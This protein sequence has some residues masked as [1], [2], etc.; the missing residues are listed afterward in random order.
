MERA[1][2]LIRFSAVL[3]LFF[4]LTYVYLLPGSEVMLEGRTD[5]VMSDDTDPAALPYMYDQLIQ[6]WK[7]APSRFFYGSVYVDNMDPGKGMAYWMSW[8]ERFTMLMAS[9]FFPVEQISTAVVFVMLLLNA[10]SMFALARFLG[11]NIWLS[12]GAAIAWAFNPFTRARATVHMA[13]AG[14]Y[15]LPLIVLALLLVARGKSWR[16]TA[17]AAAALVLACTVNHYFV[18][19]AAF[20]SP[21]FLLFLFFQP[22]SRAKPKRVAKR[23]AL[24]VLPAVFFLGFGFT[25]PV[26]ADAPLNATQAM[27]RTGE[28]ADGSVHP[29]L[30]TYAARPIDYLAGDLSL[31]QGPRDLNPL[32]GSLNE[33]ILSHLDNS[34]PHERSNGIRWTL[35]LLAALALLSTVRRK[36]S[37]R[38][39]LLW[40][41]ALT[42]FG[43]WLSLSPQSPVPAL[44]PSYW[45]Q[46]LVSQVRVPSRAGVIVHFA[47]LLIVGMWLT[48]TEAKGK[49]DRWD[50]WHRYLLWPAVFPLLMLLDYPPLVQ[51][52]PMAKVRP[53]YQELQ[54]PKGACGVGMYFPFANHYY[55]SVLFYAALQQ[56]RGTD[57]TIL[58]STTDPV[59]LQLLTERFPPVIG[60]IE[61]LDKNFVIVDQM[62]RLAR[63]VPLSWIAFDP[64][65]PAG[66]RERLCRQLG[67]RMH[68]DLTCVSPSKGRSLERS[69]H[70]CL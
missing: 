17:L 16:S 24:A 27:P 42:A 37:L 26:P 29:F 20:L 70:E 66:W 38:I 48:A 45:L 33:Y 6:T 4:V 7:K 19:T 52:V 12:L 41:F 35:L 53:A 8:S 15:H 2:R 28:T 40:L 5:V 31:A 3:A 22:E 30:T 14:I 34:N 18:V 10:L 25:H 60:F 54:R 23:L 50:R 57:C 1:I 56:L 67:W 46:S 21:F 55:G 63:C 13:M 51:D 68:P 65:V 44:S 49:W 61:A 9:L 39:H 36:S 43:F 32:R 11:W 64:V 58:N 69:A 47:I 59:Q 62:Q